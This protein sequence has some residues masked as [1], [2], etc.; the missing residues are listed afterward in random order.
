MAILLCVFLLLFLL[1]WNYLSVPRIT[2]L[3]ITLLSTEMLPA[4]QRSIRICQWI[5]HGT[6]CLPL[7]NISERDAGLVNPPDSHLPRF[8]S[9]GYEESRI[10][11]S[12]VLMSDDRGL[13]NNSWTHL[14]PHPSL[15]NVQPRLNGSYVWLSGDRRRNAITTPVKLIP[16]AGEGQRPER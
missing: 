13:E 15:D 4:R 5:C 14:S 6:F 2:F 10:S 12:F 8:P 7:H 1:L 3:Y 16:R 9:R 11:E